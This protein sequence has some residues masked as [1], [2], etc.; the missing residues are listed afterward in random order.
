MA[1]RTEIGGQPRIFH[2]F[3]GVVG[4]EV[5]FG[6]IGFAVAF[7]DQDLIPGLIPGGAGSGHPVVPGI[8]FLVHRVDID[9][10]STVVEQV[11][12]DDLPD[13][14]LGDPGIHGVLRRL[15]TLAWKKVSHLSK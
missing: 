7:V 9:D 11:V 8:I 13:G 10:D 6:D 3:G 15:P 5:S 2:R 12:L 14:K 1:E 4:T